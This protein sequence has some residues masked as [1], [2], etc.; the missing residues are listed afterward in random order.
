MENVGYRNWS[1]KSGNYNDDSYDYG[2]RKQSTGKS[3][4]SNESFDYDVS[5]DFA[6]SPEQYP[7]KGRKS[8]APEPVSASASRFGV[9]RS[10]SS[11]DERTKEIL[12]RN[13]A[14]GKNANADGDQYRLKS[15]H[16]TY[17]ELM[18]GLDYKEEKD[19]ASSSPPPAVSNK[20]QQQA[21]GSR[22]VDVSVSRSHLSVSQSR[23]DSGG[24]FDSPSLGRSDSLEISDADLEVKNDFPIQ[25]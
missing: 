12:E 8:T 4:Y 11:I 24:S 7:K 3:G 19:H 23:M 9:T 1:S 17:A 10:R 14:V 18:E 20:R 25:N 2:S 22:A 6:E 15:Y 21:T 13:K 5:S 16:D